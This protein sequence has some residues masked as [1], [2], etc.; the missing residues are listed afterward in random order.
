MKFYVNQN[1]FSITTHV[2]IFMAWPHKQ[3]HL[4]NIGVYI[5]NIKLFTVCHQYVWITFTGV[6]DPFGMG[7][8]TTVL[9]R[10]YSAK[11][12]LGHI[13][14]YPDP[15]PPTQPTRSKMAKWVLHIVLHVLYS[16]RISGGV[17]YAL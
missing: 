1:D 9:H 13:F 17:F 6:L 7:P 10:V 8:K 2:A 15:P 16:S 11:R 12:F 3:I 14:T 5:S 4:V